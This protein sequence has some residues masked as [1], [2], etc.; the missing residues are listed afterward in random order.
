M[1]FQG[2]V[3]LVIN[4]KKKAELGKII[5]SADESCLAHIE[6]ALGS[7]VELSKQYKRITRDK[8]QGGGTSK[9]Y[10]THPAASAPYW[11]IALTLKNPGNWGHR[12][13]STQNTR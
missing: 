1:I 12:R 13:G 10:R 9:R 7:R 2:R 6:V 5:I 11:V 3:S 8:G 4:E